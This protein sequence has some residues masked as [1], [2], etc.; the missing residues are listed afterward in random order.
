MSGAGTHDPA[1]GSVFYV[2][3]L[4]KKPVGSGSSSGQ[5]NPG[6]VLYVGKGKGY[7]WSFHFKEAMSKSKGLKAKAIRRALGNNP[8]P[9]SFE[10]HAVIVAGRL[11]EAEALRLEAAMLVLV[12][13][14]PKTQNRVSGHGAGELMVPAFDARV[15]FGAADQE[16]DQWWIGNRN[17][18]GGLQPSQS[19]LARSKP[20]GSVVFVVKGTADSFS[21]RPWQRTDKKGRFPNSK[22]MVQTGKPPKDRRG[23]DPHSPWT[24]S[25]A[26]AR[27]RRFWDGSP[28]S[29]Q[30]WQ[31]LIESRGGFLA[32]G[33][34]DP[35]DGRTVVRYIWKLNPSGVWEDYGDRFGFPLGGLV[36]AHPWLGKRLVN[37]RTGIGLL[38]GLQRSPGVTLYE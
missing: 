32:L 24:G 4:L 8:T 19:D 15:F 23:W 2:Y 34:P 33:V 25:E 27:A 10:K 7:R 9:E 37:N 6:N 29:V 17:S 20:Q 18:A 21:D 5:F 26:A 13:G 3:L 38:K 36:P 22:V 35:R 1:P 31:Q 30:L 11:S 16:V 28:N 14:V 12:G